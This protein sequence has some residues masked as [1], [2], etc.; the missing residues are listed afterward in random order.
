MDF[1]NIFRLINLGI[2]AIMVLGG[3]S[4]FFPPSISSV[5]VGV[6]VI[7]FGL[8]VGALEF[9]PHPPSY[10]SRHASFLFSFIGRGIFYIFV[11]CILIEGKVLRI[12]AGTIVGVV[13][14]GYVA[15]EFVPSIE[16]P[17]TMREADSTWGSE[18]V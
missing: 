17:P 14:L 7:L 2:G 8:A 3:V 11:G 12:I 1:S 13:G 4:Q 9:V 5:V 18:Q 6:Y 15:L 16:P 10:L